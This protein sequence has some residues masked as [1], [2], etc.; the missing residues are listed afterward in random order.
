MGHKQKKKLRR[1]VT[2]RFVLPLAGT[3]SAVSAR[4]YE[5]AEDVPEPQLDTP[6]AMA[7]GTALMEMEMELA[8]AETA[9]RAVRNATVV[10]TTGL[11]IAMVAIF[12]LFFG[13]M[14]IPFISPS[15]ALAHSLTTTSSMSTR[16]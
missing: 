3:L 14:P 8:S 16:C 11:F 12:S 1:G 5:M 6:S 9:R 10:V 2:S 15:K 13:G 4:I 7:E